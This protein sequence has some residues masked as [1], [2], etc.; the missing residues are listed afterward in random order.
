[1][2]TVSVRMMVK[3]LC[4]AGF[5]ELTDCDIQGLLILY[6]ENVLHY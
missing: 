2:L 5:K 3:T 6:G 4:I 1:M